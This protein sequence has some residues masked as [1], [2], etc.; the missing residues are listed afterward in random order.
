MIFPLKKDLLKKILEKK[1]LLLFL[2]Y[3][4]TLSAIASRPELAILNKRTKKLLQD[5]NS[6]C[7]CSVAIISGRSLKDIRKRVNVKGLIYVGNHGFE[8]F[9][10]KICFK[11]FYFSRSLK[12]FKKILKSLELN[13]GDFKGLIIEDKGATLSVHYR[14]VDD[15]KVEIFEKSFQIMIRPYVKRQEIRVH[16]GKKVYEIRPPV[17]WNKGKAVLW[18]LRNRKNILKNKNANI[19]YI[20]DDTTDEDAFDV[21]KEMAITIRVGKSESSHAKYYLKDV[22]DV[23]LLLKKILLLKKQKS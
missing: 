1:S 17:D 15:K 22:K 10:P 18:L 23:Q 2:D 4:G 11:K 13:F 12:I 3:D 14:L 20:G 9:G 19:I 7:D 21:L 16:K 8:I 5:L 6:L